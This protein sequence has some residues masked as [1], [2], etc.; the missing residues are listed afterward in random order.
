[1]R[2]KFVVSF[3][4]FSQLLASSVPG[5]SN[6]P[7]EDE[8]QESSLVSRA[9]RGTARLAQDHPYLTCAAAACVTSLAYWYGSSDGCESYTNLLLNPRGSSSEISVRFVDGVI[10]AFNITHHLFYRGY[11]YKEYDG[12][13]GS[14]SR[15]IVGEE[16]QGRELNIGLSEEIIKTFLEPIGEIGSGLFR[17]FVPS[18]SAPDPRIKIC[19]KG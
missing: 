7:N 9:V 1:M 8:V 14:E 11:E 17:I 19:L 12:T 2:F 10:E 16:C 3:I 4:V 6:P 15:C 13:T 5:Q 18:L